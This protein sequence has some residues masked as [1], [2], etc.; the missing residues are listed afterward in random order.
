MYPHTLSG[1][2]L[3]ELLQYIQRFWEELLVIGTV[4]MFT[5]SLPLIC[6]ANTPLRKT[7][8]LPPRIATDPIEALAL[9]GESPG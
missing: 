5:A 3:F 2:R 1:Q 6:T 9:V 8:T 4:G 7:K